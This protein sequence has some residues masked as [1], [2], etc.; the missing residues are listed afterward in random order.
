MSDDSIGPCRLGLAPLREEPGDGSIAGGDMSIQY[1]P[2]END[3][4]RDPVWSLLIKRQAH[5][6][7]SVLVSLEP[8][9]GM[10]RYRVGWITC[11]ESEGR[12]SGWLSSGKAALAVGP[13]GVIAP[14]SQQFLTEE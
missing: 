4:R 14:K 1:R 10:A 7:V 12:E 11:P 9:R 8:V 3:E 2:E 13:S 5:I 6:S